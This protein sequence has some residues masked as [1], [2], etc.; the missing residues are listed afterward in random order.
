M[1]AVKT[2]LGDIKLKDYPFYYLQQYIRVNPHDKI[3]KKIGK[4]W[5]DL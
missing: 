3:V 5:K 2:I 1:F 4:K